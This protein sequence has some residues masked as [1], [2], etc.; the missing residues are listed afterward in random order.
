MPIFALSTGA[1]FCKGVEVTASFLLGT[2]FQKNESDGKM[3]SENKLQTWKALKHLEPY[4]YIQWC[5]NYSGRSVLFDKNRIKCNPRICQ[6]DLLTS[7]IL[8]SSISKGHRFLGFLLKIGDLSESDRK[9]Q[10]VDF[11]MRWIR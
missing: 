8:F 3:I 7:K 6:Q 1:R 4:T 11:F 2:I 5:A 10:P 9:K